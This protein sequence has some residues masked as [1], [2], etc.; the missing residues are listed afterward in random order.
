MSAWDGLNRRKFPRI[1]FPCLV[2]IREPDALPDAILTHTENVGI[3]GICVLIKK[4]LKIYTK[5]DLEIDLLDLSDHVHCR[6]KVVWT[7]RRKEHDSNKPFFF[8]I[9]IEFIDLKEEDAERLSRLIEN[10]VRKD[11]ESLTA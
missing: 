2:I 7:V 1:N 6:G 5:V 10:A 9:G 3:G 11:P 4:N 8:D